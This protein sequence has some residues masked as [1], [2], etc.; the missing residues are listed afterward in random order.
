MNEASPPLLRVTG[1]GHRFAGARAG[2][3]AVR[4]ATLELHAGEVLAIVGES[5][6]GK[7]TL[8]NCVAGRIVPTEGQVLYRPRAG[9]VVDVHAVGERRRRELARSE[10]GF[11]EQHAHEGLR[12]NVSA[13][14]NVGERLMGCARPPRA[15]WS[16]WNW[17][18]R[19]WTIRRVAFRAAC[20]SACRSRATW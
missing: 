13:G 7:S 6:S 9:G 11:V 15:G 12:M 2:H 17:T 18:R 8:L 3:W 14:A 10:W 20:A 16:A 1:L 4:D 5:G 19:A